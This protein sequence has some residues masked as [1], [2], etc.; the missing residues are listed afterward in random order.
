[1]KRLFLFTIG[2]VSCVLIMAQIQKGVVKTRGRIVNGLLQPGK[3]LEGASVLI[4]EHS[5]ILSGN[6]GK[7]S[8]PVTNSSFRIKD[9][10]KNG[11][12]LVDNGVCTDYKYSEN[13]LRLVMD[14]PEQQR[15]DQLAIERKIRCNL[16]NQLKEREEEIEA[17]KISQKEKDSLIYSLYQLH[18]A[19][20][21]LIADMAKRYVAI[22]YDQLDDFYRHVSFFIENGNLDRADSLLR[23]RGDINAQVKQ[24][25]RQGL[26][27]SEE[28]TKLQQAKS[29]NQLEIDE[30]A[31]RCFSYYESFFAQQQFDSAGYYLELR[32][33]LDTKNIKWKLEAG[34]Y[35]NNYCRSDN[36]F[37]IA[38]KYYRE[39]LCLAIEKYGGDSPITGLCYM[40]MGDVEDLGKDL[41]C[42]TLS[43]YPKALQ[44]L[45]K[46]YGEESLEVAT[47]LRR[48]FI[49]YMCQYSFITRLNRYL[50]KAQECATKAYEIYKKI[51]GE[52]SVEAAVSYAEIGD[53][54]YFLDECIPYYNKALSVL[55]KNGYYPEQEATIYEHMANMY[56]LDVE[57]QRSIFYQAETLYSDS[58]R[59]KNTDT[60]EDFTQKDWYYFVKWQELLVAQSEWIIEQYTTAINYYQKIIDLLVPEYGERYAKVVDIKNDI[61][62]INR[63]RETEQYLLDETQKQLEKAKEMMKR[64]ARC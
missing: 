61:E 46:H 54:Q 11:Y 38:E 27:I 53:T 41:G 4:N 42:N 17:L 5:T 20:E 40:Y 43:Y 28:E 22:D 45:T 60:F 23:S 52:E 35:I 50:D 21:K 55:H 34:E 10:Q 3:G 9:V 57:L 1:M 13:P 8:F 14:T 19:N 39:A 2:L 64:Q 33:S 48:L 12:L 37:N 16:Q 31:L 30:A 29:V 36:Y 51:Y 63:D 49:V 44:L 15:S 7:F 58:I 59:D 56:V 6:D 26:A 32:A 47:C 25:L 62:D 24:I 18:G